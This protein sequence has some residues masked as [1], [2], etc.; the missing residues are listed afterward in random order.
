[1]TMRVDPVTGDLVACE[2]PQADATEQAI[3]SVIRYSSPVPD[4]RYRIMWR[5]VI[6]DI[7]E[8][9]TAKDNYWQPAVFRDRRRAER[10]L[11]R[12]RK[13]R[14]DEYVMVKET[15]TYEVCD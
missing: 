5:R 2:P 3:D 7:D 1:M 6:L 12:L 10:L 8:W 15:I 9:L 4:V 13:L 14:P 11:K